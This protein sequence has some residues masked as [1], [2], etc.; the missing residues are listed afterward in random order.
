MIGD[1]YAWKMTRFIW[2][3][4]RHV[5]YRETSIFDKKEIIYGSEC[6]GA[7]GCRYRSIFL[8]IIYGE[9]CIIVVRR[10]Y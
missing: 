7:R 1:V 4:G 2:W 5:R 9:T 8:R 3:S 10:F 6:E